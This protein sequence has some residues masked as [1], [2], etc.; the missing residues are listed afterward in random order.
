MPRDDNR[1]DLP[2]SPDEPASPAE[3]AQAASFATLIDQL[4]AD[5]RLPPAM[6]S[7]E[8]ALV[9]VAAMVR[10]SV[11][12]VDLEPARRDVLIDEA[13][14]TA[15]AQA[16]RPAGE[17]AS[18]GGPAAGHSAGDSAG[19]PHG[20]PDA[21]GGA[22]VIDLGARRRRLRSL[23][24]WTIATAA[25]AAA[26]VLALERPAPQHT[27][28]LH[29]QAEPDVSEVHRS[30]PADALIGRI[31]RDRADRASDRLDIIYADRLAGY[32]DLRLRGGT[33]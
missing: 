28:V 27:A 17:D 23:V 15:R 18:P 4:V 1:D 24:P 30:R 21:P 20:D 5:G 29:P 2:R 11:R 25:A 16:D 26:L 12:D 31:P 9:D 22:D 14:A 33:R 3:S 7:D 6:T 19:D 13:L 8:R 10:A 32:R